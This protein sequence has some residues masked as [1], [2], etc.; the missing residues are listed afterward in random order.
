MIGCYVW[1]PT[2]KRAPA[3]SR[4]EEHRSLASKPANAKTAVGL[5]SIQGPGISHVTPIAGQADRQAGGQ[6]GRQA[7]STLVIFGTAIGVHMLR[8][9]RES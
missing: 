4:F 9:G 8:V 5:V 2:D 7:D 3:R 1:G 6:A